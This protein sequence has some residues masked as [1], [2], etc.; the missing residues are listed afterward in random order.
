MEAEVNFWLFAGKG[1]Y[2]GDNHDWFADREHL[3]AN[4]ESS[5]ELRARIDLGDGVTFVDGVAVDWFAMVTR[6]ARNT[7]KP[8]VVWQ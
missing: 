4:A 3:V 1:L 5:K 7:S 2:P 8:L 6:D